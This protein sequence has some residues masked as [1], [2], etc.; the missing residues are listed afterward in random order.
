MRYRRGGKP[1]RK[2]S[3]QKAFICVYQCV[4][5]VDFLF[6]KRGEALIV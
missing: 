6:F 4:S 1:Y 5:V 2:A 3:H